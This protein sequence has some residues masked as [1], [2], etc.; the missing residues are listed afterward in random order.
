MNLE[1]DSL[2]LGLSK[3]E[4]IELACRR[5]SGMSVNEAATKKKVRAYMKKHPYSIQ[6]FER[7]LKCKIQTAKDG[8]IMDITRKS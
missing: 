1:F 4:L 7:V 5:A 6:D 8:S 2:R 3:D